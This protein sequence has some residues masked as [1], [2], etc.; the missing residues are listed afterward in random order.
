MEKK[1]KPA[2][3]PV[4][5]RTIRKELTARGWTQRYLAAQMG[6]P[7]QKISEIIAGKKRITE[8]TALEFEDAFGI[9][10]SFWLNLESNYRLYLARKARDGR[11]A[12]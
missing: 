11:R 9:D 2:N 6:R 1:L 5:G 10:A 4:P 8:D 3:V 12:G 7:E